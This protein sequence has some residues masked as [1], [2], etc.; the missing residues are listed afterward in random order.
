M[1][2]AAKTA[3]LIALLIAA[4]VLVILIWAG[5]KL[6]LPDPFAESDWGEPE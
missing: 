6:G 4:G 5:T 1:K 3:A 2:R